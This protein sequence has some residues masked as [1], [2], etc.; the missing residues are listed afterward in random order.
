M[1]LRLASLLIVAL[2]L[3]AAPLRGEAAPPAK[4][5]APAAKPAKKGAGGPAKPAKDPDDDDDAPVKDAKPAAGAS[6]ASKDAAKPAAGATG[7]SKDAAKPAAA[8]A[9]GAGATEEEE[10]DKASRPVQLPED[11][12]PADMEGVDE[13]PDAPVDY[14]A[15][16]PTV[17]V[18]APQR[19]EGYPLEEVWRPLTLPRFMTEVALDLRFNVNPFI[20][21]QTLRARF[22]VTPEIQVGLQYNIGGIYE[23][24]TRDMA[25]NT[26]K[27]VALAGA[28][29]IREWIAAQLVVPMYLEPFAA[30]IN[31]SA[32]MKFRFGG[33]YAL[34]IAEDLIDIRVAK[35]VP[36]MTSEAANEVNVSNENTNTRTDAG[37]F[38]FQGA[39]IFQYKPDLALIGRVAVTIIDF[40]SQRL[41]YMVKVGGQMTV[42]KSL[43]LSANLGFDDLGD[44]DNTFGLQL[45]AAFRI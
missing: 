19:P 5:K 35:F 41:G 23:D 32:P 9:A 42:L 43:D 6:G 21:G 34:L 28:Y 14:D 31:L 30:S 4:G 25:F 15:P 38:R 3:C 18:E 44:A 36:S 33:R 7:A 22:G 20:N 39:G 37:N 10:L 1:S 17:V 24:G 2:G 16:P 29:K 13:N 8:G 27:A 40:D 45:G 11:P 26:G 12:P